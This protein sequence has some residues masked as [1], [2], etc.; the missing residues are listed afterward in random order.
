[1][2]LLS[3]MALFCAFHSLS[4]AQTKLKIIPHGGAIVVSNLDSSFAWYAPLF[5]LR[6]VSRTT[7]PGGN[8]KVS[9]AESSTFLLELLELKSSLSS[10]SIL[11]DKPAGTHL[12]GHFKLFFKCDNADQFLKKLSGMK[13]SVPRVWKDDKTGKRNFI[14][15]DPDGNMIQF[16]E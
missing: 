16:F 11:R 4:N 8:Y 12:Q 5:E 9:I 2:R 14:I 10:E 3:L 15:N 1:M 7:D 13:I 6:E